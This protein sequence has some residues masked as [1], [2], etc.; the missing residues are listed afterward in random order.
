MKHRLNEEEQKELTF[1]AC[2][3]QYNEGVN[4]NETAKH[5]DLLPRTLHRYRHK[6]PWQELKE[7]FTITKDLRSRQI[8][9][10]K[11]IPEGVKR[12]ADE[13]LVKMSQLSYNATVVL[14]TWVETLIDKINSKDQEKLNAKGEKYLVRG[15]DTIKPQDLDRLIRISKDTSTLIIP[16]GT[17]VD[18]TNNTQRTELVSQFSEARRLLDQ[19]E[20]RNGKKKG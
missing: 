16:Q 11:R 13:N 3:Y 14:S 19:K 20:K 12:Q 9:V 2:E 7:E 8:T 1:R 6:F 18:E 10:E 17:T 4:W 15:I 5:F